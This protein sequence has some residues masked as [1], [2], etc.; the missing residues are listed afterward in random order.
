MMTLDEWVDRLPTDH[1]AR[2][3]LAGLRSRIGDLKESLR[4]EV[5]ENERLRR[6]LPD[7]MD[8]CTIRF[9][10][11]EH[12]HGRLTAINWVQHDCQTCEINTLKQRI[13]EMNAMM[14]DYELAMLWL[15]GHPDRKI[16]L[17]HGGQGGRFY[18]KMLDENGDSPCDGAGVTAKDAIGDCG[19]SLIINPDGTL[20]VKL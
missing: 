9:L 19:R 14:T 8:H 6:Q 5:L 16:E 17:S 4:L 10:E 13:K 1:P 12:G 18:A 2:A 7:G 11:C 3:E 20:R 15:A